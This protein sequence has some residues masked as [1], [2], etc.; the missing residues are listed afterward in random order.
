MVRVRLRLPYPKPLEMIDFQGVFAC[1]NH[2]IHTQYPC[3]I[4]VFFQEISQ[5][6]GV[7]HQDLRHVYAKD[8][9][10]LSKSRQFIK[11]NLTRIHN[12]LWV[13]GVFD[14]LH[15]CQCITVLIRHIFALALPHAM[16]AGASPAHLYR[17]LC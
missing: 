9:S 16:L 5:K 15:Y 8:D 11:P 4:L 14:G 10:S 3:W 1:T 7:N 17:T 13:N 12:A 2:P 6:N